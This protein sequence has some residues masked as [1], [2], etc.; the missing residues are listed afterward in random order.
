M[1]IDQFDKDMHYLYSDLVRI[2]FDF[3]DS[4]NSEISD[5]YLFGYIEASTW[6]YYVLQDKRP[7]YKTG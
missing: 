7:V 4:D 2:A 5:I 3:I 1:T 6:F